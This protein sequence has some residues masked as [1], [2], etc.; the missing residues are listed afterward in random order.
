[1]LGDLVD[2]LDEH[3][4]VT[5]SDPVHVTSPTARALGTIVDDDEAL[6]GID[7][8]TVEEGDEGETSPPS[9]S[10]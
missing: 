10:T 2:E 8:Q 9:P 7:D 6:L 1:M 4:T 3:Y 5:L